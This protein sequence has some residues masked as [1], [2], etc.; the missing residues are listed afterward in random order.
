MEPLMP[1]SSTIH[2]LKSCVRA[3]EDWWFDTS[4]SVRTSHNERAFD[5]SKIV[6][7]LRDSLTYGPVRVANARAALHVLPIRDCSQYTF[8]DI[9]SGKGRVLFLAAELPFRKVLG[10]EFATELHREACDNIRRYNW[11]KQK[12]PSIESI[13]A[14]AAEFEF[15][16]DNLVIYLF[17]PF[18]PEIMTRM[19]ANLA[20]S[21]E[22]T[23]RHVIILMLWPEQSRLVEQM[24]G[25]EVYKKTRRY[26]I[27]QTAGTQ[28][29][30]TT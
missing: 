13:N 16:N 28:Q 9:G 24:P 1:A 8:I 26:H 18:G 6:G 29:I 2:T 20:R 12:C 27:Y 11:F 30:R 4:R 23:P 7:H 19:L 5:A 25:I 14:D 17:N 10:V 15:P 21:I 22:E 3:V